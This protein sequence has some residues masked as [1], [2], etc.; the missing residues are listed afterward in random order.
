[1]REATGFQSVGDEPCVSRGA[2]PEGGGGGGG[3]G[4]MLTL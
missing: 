3:G 2:E 1:M 4:G